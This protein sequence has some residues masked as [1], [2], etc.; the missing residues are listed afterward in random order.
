MYTF[1]Q[2]PMLRND[3][4]T[5]YECRDSVDRGTSAFYFL[6]FYLNFYFARLIERK[7]SRPVPGADNADEPSLHL[8]A[9]NYS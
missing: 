5:N 7:I 9:N 2:R 6:K 8:I 4:E 3:V 1:I